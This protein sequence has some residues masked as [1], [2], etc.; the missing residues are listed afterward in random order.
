MHRTIED[1]QALL[2]K[3]IVIMFAITTLFVIVLG[4]SSGWSISTILLTLS[5][6][7][8]SGAVYFIMKD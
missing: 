6:M 8:L 2:T 1:A 4:L 5:P 7:Y 3:I